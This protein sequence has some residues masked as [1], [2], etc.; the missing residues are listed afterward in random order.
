MHPIVTGDGSPTLFSERYREAY[1]PKE[2]ARAQAER[3]FVRLAGLWGQAE[4]RVVEVGFGLG[5][6]FLASL[7]AIRAEDG[8]LF[9]LG[10]EPEPVT[11]EVLAEVLAL[12]RLAPDA[13]APLLAAWERGRDFVVAGEG[14]LL[15]VR[16]ARLEHT[17]LPKG[18][19][20]AVYYDPF[21]PRANPQAWSLAN[22]ARARDGLRPGGVLLSYAVAGWVRRNL[23]ALGFAVERVPGELGKR[24]WLRARRIS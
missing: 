12:C 23:E 15:E 24:A 5:L 7:E 6:N 10:L 22:L 1:H 18:W 17:R 4:A 14:F 21:S 9:F 3:L 8:H 11:P 16:F 2:G 20:D 13:H 19:A